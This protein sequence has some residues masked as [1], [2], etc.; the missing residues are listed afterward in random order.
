HYTNF[1]HLL[2]NDFC[3]PA[4]TLWFNNIYELGENFYHIYENTNVTTKINKI[5]EIFK[6]TKL[7]PDYYNLALIK[8]QFYA[9]KI[10]K[11]LFVIDNTYIATIKLSI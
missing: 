5:K 10:E 7:R 3:Y 4:R 6:T 2:F 1:Y 9:L 8:S 11:H